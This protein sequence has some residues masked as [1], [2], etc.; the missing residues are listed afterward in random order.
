[1]GSG[2]LGLE[3]LDARF[4]V[5]FFPRLIFRGHHCWVVMSGAL[6]VRKLR[7]TKLRPIH[8]D[9]LHSLATKSA[10]CLDPIIYHVNMHRTVF[11][12]VY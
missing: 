9:Q 1:M 10:G 8:T 7:I 2:F 11:S 6:K 5:V 3:T 12:C 4:D